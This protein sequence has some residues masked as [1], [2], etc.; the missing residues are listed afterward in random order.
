[1][2]LFL[3]PQ[4]NRALSGLVGR[5]GLRRRLVNAG[6][7]RLLSVEAV[8]S[9]NPI[10]SHTHCERLTLLAVLPCRRIKRRLSLLLSLC[11]RVVLVRLFDQLVFH[12]LVVLLVPLIE[13]VGS[14]VLLVRL[15]LVVVLPP[16][17]I[18]LLEEPIFLRVFVLE[19]RLLLQPR[20]DRVL[21]P[22]LL[23]L[24]D[25]RLLLHRLPDRRIGSHG[26]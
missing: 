15:S 14:S 1:M 18:V 2:E 21:I 8:V 6:G 10:S 9:V 25:L 4:V 7:T 19:I 22:L 20:V 17:R 16:L 11:R 3:P 23:A 12:G 13:L 5:L 24:H 26:F